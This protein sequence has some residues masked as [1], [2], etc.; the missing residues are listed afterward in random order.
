VTRGCQEIADRGRSP[1]TTQGSN[2]IVTVDARNSGGDD[3]DASDGKIEMVRKM[4]NSL[5]KASNG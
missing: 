1:Q 5:L 2:K 3:T 4:P